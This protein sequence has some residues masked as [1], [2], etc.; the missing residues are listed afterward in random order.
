MVDRRFPPGSGNKDKINNSDS[1][2]PRSG[3]PATVSLPQRRATTPRTGKKTKLLAAINSPKKTGSGSAARVVTSTESKRGRATDPRR[4]QR[5][6]FSFEP[7][8]SATDTDGNA[9]IALEAV[10]RSVQLKAHVGAAGNEP[11]RV[12]PADESTTEREGKQRRRRRG[13]RRRQEK[14]QEC[15]QQ[16]E[17]QQQQQDVGQPSDSRRQQ[18]A[19][20]GAIDLLRARTKSTTDVKP[21]SAEKNKLLPAR[22]LTPALGTAC[23]GRRPSAEERRERLLKAAGSVAAAAVIDIAAGE[24]PRGDVDDPAA[25]QEHLASNRGKQAGA[26]LRGSRGRTK[27]A[28]GSS[29]GGQTSSWTNAALGVHRRK[30]S[31]HRRAVTPEADDVGEREGVDGKFSRA[32]AET[33]M[34]G[35]IR[36]EGEDHAMDN[37]VATVTIS[38]DQMEA[39]D[40]TPCSGSIDAVADFS[41]REA[42]PHDDE[43]KRSNSQQRPLQMPRQLTPPIVPLSASAQRPLSSRRPISARVQS[44]TAAFDGRVVSSGDSTPENDPNF[45]AL[46]SGLQHR[47]EREVAVDGRGATYANGDGEAAASPSP[48]SVSSGSILYRQDGGGSTSEGEALL[49]K[50]GRSTSYASAGSTDSSPPRG[51]SILN[52]LEAAG[53]TTSGRLDFRSELEKMT[54]AAIAGVEGPVLPVVMAAV[55]ATA[56]TEEVKEEGADEAAGVRVDARPPAAGVVQSTGAAAAAAAAVDGGGYGKD[57][58][59]LEVTIL[60][61]RE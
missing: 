10:A 24:Q 59:K 61:E 38:G 8:S 52:R 5:E 37:G 39:V 30:G 6:S 28:L 46:F 16:E 3:Y 17:E 45:H 49:P 2:S 43:R 40:V 27:S 57:W 20:A 25:P 41:S 21:S 36:T 7:E 23:H 26:L 60:G 53:Q 4:Q 54:A 31:S 56:V 34:T 19:G 32:T 35:F 50:V 13:R 9:A 11:G 55:V 12:H 22:V 48:L 47:H 44:A 18:F 1:V 42:V 15:Q 33:D 14:Q 58:D 51:E 29:S